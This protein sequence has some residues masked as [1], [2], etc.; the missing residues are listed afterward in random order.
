LT[1]RKP[2]LE[3][4]ALTRN[5]EIRAAVLALVLVIQIDEEAVHVTVEIR[6]VQLDVILQAIG[7]E[8]AP[9]P[10]QHRRGIVVAHDSRQAARD[11]TQSVCCQS[12]S[13]DRGAQCPHATGC[14]RH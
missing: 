11:S 1:H 14:A 8:V 2:V 9:R 6:L 12:N 3:R 7:A 13:P 10:F 5:L 4:F